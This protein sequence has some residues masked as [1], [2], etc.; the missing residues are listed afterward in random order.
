VGER[1]QEN[2]L[3]RIFRQF[4]VFKVFERDTQQQGGIPLQ[5]VTKPL[6]IVAFAVSQ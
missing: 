3:H 5:Q 2:L 1:F 4:P 6:V